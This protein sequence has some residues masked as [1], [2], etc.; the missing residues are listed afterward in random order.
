[1]SGQVWTVSCPKGND[2]ALDYGFPNLGSTC[3]VSATLQS[4]RHCPA[5]SDALRACASAASHPPASP[6]TPRNDG[7]AAEDAPPNRPLCS[8]LATL[9]SGDTSIGDEGSALRMREN[10]VRFLR[11][12]HACGAGRHMKVLEQNDVHE[13]LMVL[14]DMLDRES[15]RTVQNA[16]DA[17]LESST[18]ASIDV[19][20]AGTAAATP[21]F[22]GY[23]ALSAKMGGI[24]KK[25]FFRDCGA[26]AYMFAGYYVSQMKCASCARTFH[27]GEQMHVLPLPLSSSSRRFASVQASLADFFGSEFIDEWRCSS[28]DYD[29][30]KGT[31]RSS[32]EPCRRAG[33]TKVYRIW[34]APRV[35]LLL[36]QRFRPDGSKDD[37]PIVLNKEVDVAEWTIG[38]TPPPAANGLLSRRRPHSSESTERQQNPLTTKFSLSSIVCHMGRYASSGHYVA[39]AANKVGETIRW[40]F[41]DDDVVFPVSDPSERASQDAYLLVYTPLEESS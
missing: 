1:M 23:R 39:L 16:I 18:Y 27:N 17:S 14:L 35:L 38:P 25:L 6:Q 33:G 5:F 37:T 20:S 4:L 31:G 26:A 13:F 7:A 29:D 12:F 9:L 10:V 3:Y 15:A 8:V 32:R 21:P 34:W 40:R 22:D 2:D 24:W 30:R 11:T 28:A 36:L 41:Y 19:D